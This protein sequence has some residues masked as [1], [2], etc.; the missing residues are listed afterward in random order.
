M[1]YY[2]YKK[3]ASSA[4]RAVAGGIKAQNKRGAFGQ[5]WW[6]KQWITTV[7]EPE[8]LEILVLG[9]GLVSI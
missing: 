8:V 6:G 5:K 3:P 2:W 1:E 9:D 4:P 7:K